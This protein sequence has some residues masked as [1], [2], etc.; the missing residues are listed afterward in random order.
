MISS[1]RRYTPTER[2]VLALTVV[3]LMLIVTFPFYWIVMT[4]LKTGRAVF[5]TTQVI[6]ARQLTVTN[7]IDLFTGTEILRWVLVTVS[8]AFVSTAFALVVSVLAAYSI[9]DF[10]YRG[11][12]ALSF[13]VFIAYIVPQAM[14]FI[15]LFL[16]LN[17]MHLVNTFTG[18]VLAYQTISVPFATWLL[19]GYFR[20]LPKELKDA[21]RIDGCTPLGVL[22]RI[23]LPLAAPGVATAAIF[24]F[25]ASWNEFLYAATL[26][27]S[28]RLKT[29]SLGIAGFLVS[30]VFIWGQLM[31]AATFATV[32]ILILFVFLQRYIVQGLTMGGVK[33]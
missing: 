22:G 8:L 24:S 20:T 25:T 2:T 16:L 19:L 5:D 10:S 4:S 27:L 30:D 29:L 7:Y 32:P 31:A 17:A 14:L 15:P 3:V 23:I 11:R 13:A 21:A 26:T 1:G 18:L 6:F 9:T 28:A 12:K 33:G